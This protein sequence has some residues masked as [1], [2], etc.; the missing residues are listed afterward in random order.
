MVTVG[1][2]VRVLRQMTYFLLTDKRAFACGEN[3]FTPLARDVVDAHLDILRAGCK[4]RHLPEELIASVTG[5]AWV[6]P[7]VPQASGPRAGR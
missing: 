3:R 4:W 6:T 2:A 7:I 5:W 1:S